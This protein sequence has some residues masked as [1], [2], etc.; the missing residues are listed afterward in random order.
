[1]H[2]ANSFV[3]SEYRKSVFGAFTASDTYVICSYG[4]APFKLHEHTRVQ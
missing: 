4:T 3:N 2:V 1:M